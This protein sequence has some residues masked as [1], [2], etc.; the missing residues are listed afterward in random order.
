MAHIDYFFATISPYTY[1]AG[2]RLEAIAAKHGATISY[3]P[4]DVVTLF[5]RTGGVKPAERH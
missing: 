4:M 1:L 2:T 5:G 3:K